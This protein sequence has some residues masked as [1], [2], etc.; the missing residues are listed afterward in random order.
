MEIKCLAHSLGCTQDSCQDCA[1]L[2]L[3]GVS[4]PLRKGAEELLGVSVDLIWAVRLIP[5]LEKLSFPYVRR[6]LVVA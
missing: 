2:E 1:C 6:C 5:I 3:G 4:F